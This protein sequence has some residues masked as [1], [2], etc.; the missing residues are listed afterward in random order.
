MIVKRLQDLINKVHLPLFA[1]KC[2]YYIEKG[3]RSSG[4]S[5][6]N[7]GI[8]PVFCILQSPL[9][10]VLIVR[11]ND[12]TN[13][14]S[15]YNSIIKI[16]H[17]LNMEEY[18]SF[19]VNPLEIT[20]K[21]TGQVIYFR[22][23]NNPDTIKSITTTTGF[24]NRM[25]IEEANELPDYETFNIIDKSIRRPKFDA[26]KYKRED[27][28][29]SYIQIVCI[30]NG[31]DINTFLYDEFFKGRLEDNEEELEC[32]GYQYKYYPNLVIHNGIGLFLAT[33]SSRAN[34]YREPSVDIAAE[35]LKR[36]NLARYQVDYLGMWGKQ[37]GSTYNG[38]TEENFISWEDAVR[39]YTYWDFAIGIDTGLGNGTGKIKNG[40]VESATVCELCAVTTRYEK[41]VTLDEY[42]W[43]N[44]NSQI[45]KSPNE[46]YE[47]IA[48][49]FQN[50]ELKYQSVPK[51]MKGKVYVYVDSADAQFRE[52]L[53]SVCRR[54]GMRNYEFI[55]STKKPIL[56]R[57]RFEDLL[58][59]WNE[60]LIAKNCKNVIRE[61]KTSVVGDLGKRADGNDH[62][63]NAEEYGFAPF[64]DKMNRWLTMKTI[65]SKEN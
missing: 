3:G 49:Y 46:I 5:H 23:A 15:T 58:F 64:Y 42:F 65:S 50:L 2:R 40:Y 17:E 10:N 39:N 44:S 4:K 20:Y 22:G 14:Q 60:K 48:D 1:I 32:N 21:P 54:R 19:R 61:Y 57:V 63:I 56:D 12:N 52:N 45:K 55:G 53:K 35:E 29:N 41:Q 47:E 62:A 38:L 25:V 24:L 11:Q 34:E 30:F 8:Y 9:N 37:Q 59:T 36:R 43:S 31:I 27:Y 18:F 33:T 13:K 16:I 51:I 7:Q 6:D 26:E 28:E